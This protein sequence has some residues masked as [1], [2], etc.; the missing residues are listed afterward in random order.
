M[1]LK[2]WVGKAQIMM[3]RNQLSSSVSICVHLWLI[4]LFL[5]SAAAAS[6]HDS[7]KTPLFTIPFT[8]HPPTIDGTIDDAEWQSAFSA[9][10]LQTTEGAV[11]TRQARIWMMWDADHLYLAMRSPILQ[12]QK[13]VRAF[14]QRGRDNSKI[15]FDDSYEIWLNAGTHSPDGEPVF[16]QYLGNYAGAKYDVMFEPA[17]GNSRPGWES[18]WKPMSRITPD[19]KFWEMEVV[20]PRESIYHEKAFADGEELHGLIVRNF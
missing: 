7:Y 15:V 12:G 8:T 19:G 2:N 14:R 11:S 4:P 10:A 20:I 18:G 3:R 13:I 16:F 1:Q 9:A 5:F 6:V 17:V